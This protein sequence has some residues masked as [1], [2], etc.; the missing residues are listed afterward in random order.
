L[1]ASFAQTL[2]EAVPS[3]AA[4][5][6]TVGNLAVTVAYAD[7]TEI[8]LLPARRSGDALSIASEDGREWREIRPRKF[9]E[10]L[11]EVN[12][13]NSGVVVPAI[14]LA[15][16]IIGRLPERDQLSGYHVEAIAVDAFRSYNGSGS[17]EAVLRHL[18]DHAAGTVLRPTGDITGQTV[19]IDGHLGAGNSADRQRISAS[20][21]RVVSRMAS[22]TSVEDYKEL[23]GD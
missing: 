2:R 11:T 4:A 20:L 7:G 1:I 13:A 6:V 5:S 12:R 16:A 19:H 21:R 3:S 17:R 18:I 14:K 15:K 8:Q 23:F 10:K 9:A 22:A